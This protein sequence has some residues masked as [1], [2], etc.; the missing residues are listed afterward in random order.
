MVHMQYLMTVVL[1]FHPLVTRV[2][3]S[4]S[5]EMILLAIEV[6]ALSRMVSIIS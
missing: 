5:Q 6:S 2:I 1:W 4:L 3:V